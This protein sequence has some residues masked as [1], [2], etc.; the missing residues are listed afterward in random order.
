MG[1]M[2]VGFAKWVPERPVR[3]PAIASL[4]DC[5]KTQAQW[6]NPMKFGQRPQR[7]MDVEFQLELCNSNIDNRGAK[8]TLASC[9]IMV[10]I[11]RKRVGAP[12]A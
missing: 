9:G 3:K 12:F 2:K 5:R 11:R 1:M 10:A 4:Y 7:D 6:R 8:S